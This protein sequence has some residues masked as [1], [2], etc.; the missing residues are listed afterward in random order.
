MCNLSC[1]LLPPLVSDKSFL[2]LG[3]WNDP[4]DIFLSYRLSLNY[5]PMTNFDFFSERCVSVQ[6]FFFHIATIL[7]V[8][9]RAFTI[10]TAAPTK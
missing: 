5:L 9:C 4:V 2:V 6:G 1:V 10:G 3:F 8:A 7:T